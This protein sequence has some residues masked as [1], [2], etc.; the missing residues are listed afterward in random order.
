MNDA[1]I[2]INISRDSIFKRL[3]KATKKLTSILLF[4]MPCREEG[5]SFLSSTFP[6]PK[7]LGRLNWGRL[8]LRWG[9]VKLRLGR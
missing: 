6:L 3:A 2:A 9:I 7:M 5:P 4:Q 8:K 1:V